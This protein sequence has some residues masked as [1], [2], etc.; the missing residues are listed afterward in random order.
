MTHPSDSQS[1]FARARIAEIAAAILD[2]RLGV[3][4]GSRRLMEFRVEADPE[5]EDPDLLGMCGI[6]SQTDHL[7]LGP[8]RKYWDDDA[9]RRKDAELAENEAFFRESAL[10]MCR[11]LAGRYSR[12]ALDYAMAVMRPFQKPWGIAGGWAIELFAKE[13]CRPHADVDIAILRAHQRQLWIDLEPST[14]Q[15][16][17]DGALHDWDTADWIPSPLHEV[18]LGLSNGARLEI[19]LNEHDDSTNEWI[20]R[21]DERVRRE[22]GLAF[23]R[24]EEIP[25]LAPEIVLLYKSKAP[26]EHD[27]SDFAAALPRLSHEQ[28]V[29]LRNAVSVSAPEHPWIHSADAAVWVGGP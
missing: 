9:L 21:R 25:C 11:S 7:P 17:I 13:A 18:H 15:V 26:R 5:Q 19:L 24:F 28:R 1:A 22:L 20:Y 8:V 14:T 10:E 3:I 16:I 27:E 12:S 6:E 23:R 2:G 4:E 29:W